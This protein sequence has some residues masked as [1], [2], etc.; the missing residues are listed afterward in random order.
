MPRHRDNRHLRCETAT[1]LRIVNAKSELRMAS[2]NSQTAA[3]YESTAWHLMFSD[4]DAKARAESQRSVVARKA[5]AQ[6][7][8]HCMVIMSITV[9]VSR[10]IRGAFEAAG[11]RRQ[12]RM[13]PPCREAA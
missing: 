13:G 9:A 6:S 12:T 3:T 4:S 10:L 1:E 7:A 8:G 2:P 5:L 11:G